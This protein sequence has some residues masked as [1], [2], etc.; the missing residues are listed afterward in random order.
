MIRTLEGSGSSPLVKFGAAES[1]KTTS[2][3]NYGSSRNGFA[4]ELRGLLTTRG[5]EMGTKMGLRFTSERSRAAT[6]SATSR[7]D[8]APSRPVNTVAATASSTS[9]ASSATAT[10]PLYELFGSSPTPRP[11]VPPAPTTAE[12]RGKDLLTIPMTQPIDS[13]QAGSAQADPCEF[14]KQKLAGAGVDCSGWKIENRE[15]EAFSPTAR[16]TD[17]QVMVDFGGGKKEFY[18]AD[19]LMKSPDV[20]ICEIKRLAGSAV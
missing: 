8:T 9:T 15:F 11:H 4:S 13:P 20:A 16:Y 3:R 5:A 1:A 2:K 19:L 10:N 17:R 12:L 7:S 18:S 6:A 14:L